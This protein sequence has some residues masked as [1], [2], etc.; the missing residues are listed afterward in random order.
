M[1]RRPRPESIL[2]QS[3][4]PRTDGR[5]RQSI[6][7]KIRTARHRLTPINDIRSGLPTSILQNLGDEKSQSL[8]EQ[9][10]QNPTVHLPKPILPSP[11]TA[12]LALPRHRVLWFVVG[13]EAV[14][15]ESVDD[16]ENQGQEARDGKGL[17]N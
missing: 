9:Q 3:R 12:Q 10:S 14:Q 17:G 8:R 11:R 7:L 4:A 2:D 1:T 5:V 13:E 16:D 6:R 15:K